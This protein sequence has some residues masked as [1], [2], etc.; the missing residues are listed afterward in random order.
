[1]K[2]IALF[3]SIFV[4]ISFMEQTIHQFEVEGLTGE[5]IAFSAFEGKKILIVNVASK[6]GFTR[7]YKELQELHELHGDNL[8]I[9]GF[10]CNDFGS[11]E[12][13]SNEEIAAFCQENYGVTFLMADKVSIKGKDAHPIF[14][15]LTQKEKNGVMDTKVKWN[16]YKFLIDE[17]GRLVKGLS[18]R[19]SPLDDEIVSWVKS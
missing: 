19:V 17:E 18:S 12:P 5:K 2:I 13:G 10:P 7:Q 3:L 8:V 4:T 9:I 1:M 16:F 14:Q 6:C 15:W 11:Q